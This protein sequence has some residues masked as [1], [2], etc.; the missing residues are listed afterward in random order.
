MM[1]GSNYWSGINSGM[2]FGGMIMMILFWALVISGFVLIIRWLMGNKGPEGY[3]PRETPLDILKK[4]Y[5]KGEINQ[6]EFERMKKD[7]ES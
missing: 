3:N 5:A 1:W 2:G 4:R 7:L 6:D